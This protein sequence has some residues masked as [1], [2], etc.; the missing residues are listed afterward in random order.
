MHFRGSLSNCALTAYSGVLK[1]VHENLIAYC[2][3]IQI[4]II[5]EIVKNNVFLLLISQIKRKELKNNFWN[6]ADPHPRSRDVRRPWLARGDISKCGYLTWEHLILADEKYHMPVFLKKSVEQPKMS[7][8]FGNYK[9]TDFHKESIK[10]QNRSSF[11]LFLKKNTKVLW[12]WVFIIKNK[13]KTKHILVL[14]CVDHPLKDNM[15]KPLQSIYRQ[16]IYAS[17]ESQILSTLL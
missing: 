1:F 14:I 3:I 10:E 17:F 16:F 6:W 7:S 4:F 11:F 8:Y 5:P 15:I 9:T 12:S 13:L 2:E